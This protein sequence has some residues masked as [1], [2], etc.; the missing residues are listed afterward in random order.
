VLLLR[1]AR[2]CPCKEKLLPGRR[3]LCRA[4]HRYST[5]HSLLLP[6]S[7]Y[8]DPISFG[9]AHHPDEAEVQAAHAKY[10]ASL[11]ALFEANKKR[12]GYGDRTLEIE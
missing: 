11:T 5:A 8:G 10:V 1:A 4:A 3:T 2:C 12:L 7:R 6:L 9:P